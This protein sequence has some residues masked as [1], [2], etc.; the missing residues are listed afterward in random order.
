MSPSLHAEYLI[1]LYDFKKIQ[2]SWQI[3]TEFPQYKIL[4]KSIQWKLKSSMQV[5]GRTDIKNKIVFNPATLQS[6][7]KMMNK[8]MGWNMNIM[9]AC[10]MMY[11]L[12]TALLRFY[13]WQKSIH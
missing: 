5:N 2:F 11:V 7:Q 1:F 3:L 6:S 13:S 9:A 12:Q 10:P 8:T 4:Q